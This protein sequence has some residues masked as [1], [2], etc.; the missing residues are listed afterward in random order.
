MRNAILRNHLKILLPKYFRHEIGFNVHTHQAF[1]DSFPD[2]LDLCLSLACFVLQMLQQLQ[3]QLD[4]HLKMKD[5]KQ[6]M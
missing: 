4:R 1:L 5:Q 6:F 3:L 2:I